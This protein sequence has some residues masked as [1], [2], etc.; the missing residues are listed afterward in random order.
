VDQALEE[1][2]MAPTTSPLSHVEGIPSL[3][4]LIPKDAM[5]G[6]SLYEEPHESES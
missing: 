4:A 1:T 6:E 5:L 2:P 3:Q